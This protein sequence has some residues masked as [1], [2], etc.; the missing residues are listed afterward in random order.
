L[1]SGSRFSFSHIGCAEKAQPFFLTGRNRKIAAFLIVDRERA[2][3]FIEVL[4]FK[5]FV[6]KSVVDTK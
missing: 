6:E 4:G 3:A 2:V 1:A 5:H